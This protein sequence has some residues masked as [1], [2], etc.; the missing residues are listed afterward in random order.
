MS[1][2]DLC[3][4][5]LVQQQASETPA[6]VAVV[7]GCSQLTYRQ[8]NDRADAVAQRLRLMGVGPEVPV[9][10]CVG[11]SLE[12]AVASLGIL[13]A[14]GAYVALDPA[15]PVQRLATLLED[16]G[17]SVIVTQAD[18][19]EKLPRGKCQ[20][21]IV[22]ANGVATGPVKTT[23]ARTSGVTPGLNNIAYVIFTSG[24]TG[25]P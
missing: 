23:D 19:A 6:A 24:S 7:S 3:V 25:K 14:G 4:Q 16:S 2:N 10:L 9:A 17:A 18:V 22:D 8:L 12:L 1:L 21:L 20:Q 13:K 5:D 11:R 15:D